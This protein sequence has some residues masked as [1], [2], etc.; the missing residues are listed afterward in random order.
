MKRT[1]R[2]PRPCQRRR[3]EGLALTPADGTHDDPCAPF[4]TTRPSK[5]EPD[6]R[7]MKVIEFKDASFA[8]SGE[9]EL[10]V[11]VFAQ[12][13]DA[14]PVFQ[15]VDLEVFEGETLA[16]VGPNGCGKS[17]LLQHMNGLL[18]PTSGEVLVC[19]TPTATKAG[20]NLRA[21]RWAFA[22]STPN[23]A[24][25][26]RPFAT[27]WPSDQGTSA[28]KASSFTRGFATQWRPLACLTTN[29]PNAR[30]ST[31]QAA[32]AQGCLGGGRGSRAQG[33]RA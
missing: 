11:D 4:V 8:Y 23:A 6:G 31:C 21:A 5:A 7:R 26:A 14:R 2:W 25:S 24:C 19:G 12:P 13:K 30:R 32:A 3:F 27:R 1:G 33:A 28:W 16:I 29:T 9:N 17:T 20:A 15:H 10:G 22:C 18:R